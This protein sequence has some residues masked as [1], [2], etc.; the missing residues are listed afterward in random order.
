MISSCVIEMQLLPNP[1]VQY[2]T[3]SDNRLVFQDRLFFALSPSAHTVPFLLSHRHALPLFTSL[4]N[5]VCSY[6]PVGYGVPYNHL[7]SADSREPL[8]E[9]ALQVL[10]VCLENDVEFGRQEDSDA[11]DMVLFIIFMYTYT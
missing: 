11:G 7:V 8:V 1:W 9:V 2:L 4:L 10:C 3:S 5:I 6:D